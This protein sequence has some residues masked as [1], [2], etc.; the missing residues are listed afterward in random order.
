M[1]WCIY[2]THPEVKIDPEV[3]VP[4]WG[5]SETGRERAARAAAL[6]FAG[7]IRQVIS[8]SEQKAIETAQVFC[9][10]K[11]VFHRALR[12]LHENDRSATGF[13]PP[14]EFEATADAFFA[15]PHDSVRGWERAVDAQD[16]IVTGVKSALRHIPEDDPVLFVGH[17]AVG[18]LLMCHLMAVPISRAHDQK[19]GGSWYRFDKDWLMTQTGRNLAWTEL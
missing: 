2:L 4:D 15:K 1:S 10:R 7:D 9:G 6:P 14:L 13:L 18:T 3:P 12:F 17:G 11:G 19:R 5:L 16:R 8:S